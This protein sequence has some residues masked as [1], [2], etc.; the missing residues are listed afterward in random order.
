MNMTVEGLMDVP[1]A[2]ALAQKPYVLDSGEHIAD[3]KSVV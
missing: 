1:I 2:F 3:R